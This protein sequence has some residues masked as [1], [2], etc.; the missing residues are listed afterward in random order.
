MYLVWVPSYISNSRNTICSYSKLFAF[1]EHFNNFRNLKNVYIV[2]VPS[3][4][5]IET[6]LFVL[7][8][9]CLWFPEH[10]NTFRNFNN[11]FKAFRSVP[12]TLCAAIFSMIGWHRIMYVKLSLPVHLPACPSDFCCWPSLTKWPKQLRPNHIEWRYS[13]WS[14]GMRKGLCTCATPGHPA[15]FWYFSLSSE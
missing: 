14:N 12:H 1:Q 15:S 2:R 8:V 10:F 4:I 9:N 5:T 3:N 6:I 13:L 11:V 7:I